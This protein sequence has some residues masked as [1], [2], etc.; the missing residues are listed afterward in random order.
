M[1]RLGVLRVIDLTPAFFLGLPP[2]QE[3]EMRAFVA[4]GL[5]AG[6]L[7][8]FS[9]L[10]DRTDPQVRRAGSLEDMPLAV[11]TA[12]A[13][14]NEDAV[15]GDLQDERTTLSTNSAHYTVEDADHGSI[16]LNR[17]HTLM[18]AKAVRQVV[19]AASSTGRPVAPPDQPQQ[20]SGV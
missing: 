6:T 3:D 8:E 7:A 13:S 9:V 11:L 1:A 18:V 17:E 4:D 15:W 2:H 5:W 10:K 20:G 14:V 19:D 16:V 12:S